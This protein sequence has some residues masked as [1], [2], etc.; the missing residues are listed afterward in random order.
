MVQKRDGGF[1]LVEIMIVVAIVGLLA[2]LAIP[3]ILRTRINSNEAMAK[4]NMKTYSTALENFRAA[5]NP[6]AYPPDLATLSTA[7]PTYVD[8]VLG[9]GVKSGYVFTYNFTSATQYQ[10]VGTPVMSGITGVNTFFVDE[11][12]VIRFNDANG[13]PIE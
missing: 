2:A 9:S 6:P 13:N 11:S 10:I 5:Q 3:N 1:T 12:G 7:N 4:G 8:A